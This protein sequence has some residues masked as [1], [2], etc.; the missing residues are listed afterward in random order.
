MGGI[1]HLTGHPAGSST[2]RRRAAAFPSATTSPECT[3]IG[4]L[5]AVA[6]A[7]SPAP[8]RPRLDVNLV[9]SVLSLMEGMLPEYAM[10]EASA[11]RAP[12]RHRRAHQYLPLR[13]RQVS[14]SPVIPTSSSAACAR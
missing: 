1:R 2:C 14:S 4:L 5:S 3:A 9:D 8:A 13:R 12:H 10:D 11:A 6:S 7:M